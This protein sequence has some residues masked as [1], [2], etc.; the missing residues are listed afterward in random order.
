MARSNAARSEMGQSETKLA[1]NA[2]LV[3]L[4]DRYWYFTTGSHSQQTSSDRFYFEVLRA[5]FMIQK[6]KRV[7]MCVVAN[8]QELNLG[9]IDARNSRS[10]N[11]RFLI[12]LPFRVG[13]AANYR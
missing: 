13:R 11:V 9:C 5:L 4:V 2:S 1:A 8:L 10:Q 7:G 6:G 3:D 12:P